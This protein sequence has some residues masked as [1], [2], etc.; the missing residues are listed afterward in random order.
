MGRGLSIL[1]KRILAYAYQAQGLDDPDPTGPPPHPVRYSS[2]PWLDESRSYPDNERDPARSIIPDQDPAEWTNS[3]RV[4]VSRALTRLEK[5][6]M[7]E[8]SRQ[9]TRT[10]EISL[11][12]YGIAYHHWLT[13]SDPGG[14]THELPPTPQRRR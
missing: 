3:Q 6:G 10:Q 2:A 4:A 7:I 13:S 1:Q 14:T 12:D 5:R 8:R 11:T 9:R